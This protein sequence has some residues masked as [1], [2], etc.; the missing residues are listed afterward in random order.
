MGETF[1][2]HR[3]RYPSWVEVAQVLKRHPGPAE[4]EACVVTHVALLLGCAV[5][6]TV[7]LPTGVSL[8]ADV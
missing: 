4:R 8:S 3:M 6:I 5:V 1:D 2:P 7:P